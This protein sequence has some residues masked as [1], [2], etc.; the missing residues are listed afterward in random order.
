MIAG[1]ELCPRRLWSLWEM[2]ELKAGAFYNTAT[3]MAETSAWIGATTA[4]TAAIG[5]EGKDGRLFHKDTRLD[6]EDRMFLDG[7][8]KGLREHLD[9]LGARVTALAA[10]DAENTLANVYTATW[11]TARERFEEIKNTLRRE[12]SLQTL[13]V[14]EPKE[15][16]YFTPKEPHFGA[17]VAEKF[18]TDATFEIDEAA[19]CLAFGRSTGAVFH[20][21]RV[22][23]IG[24]RAVTRCLAIPDP[25]RRAERNW[26]HILG[27][28]K[29]DLD[30]HGGAA[31]TKTWKVAGDRE[32]FE[33]AY[34]SLDAV[35]VAWRNTTM[36]V[37][38]K[39]T[40]D[41]AEHIFRRGARVYETTRFPL[42]R[43]RRAEGLGDPLGCS[44][45]LRNT[46]SKFGLGCS[47][48]TSRAMSIKRF[49]SSGSS[50]GGLGLRGM[51]AT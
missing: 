38:K 25:T 47:A 33:G 9:T 17:E 30:A 41:E 12:L 28:I 11:G 42:R 19:K 14:L 36:H 39:Y 3:R 8:L 16:A 5:E 15:Q 35:R 18:P 37:E 10:Q 51:C 46:R 43:E 40:G 49:D 29:K 27:E 6:E 26:G 2:F 24:I 31:P 48:P 22:M 4:A 45:T 7:R 23:E 13:L 34:A 32:F 21:M 44:A 1:E 50:G 20:L